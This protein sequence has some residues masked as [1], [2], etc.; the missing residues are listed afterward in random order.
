MPTVRAGDLD[1]HYTE[2]GA[3]LPMVLLHGGLATADMWNPE[4]VATLAAH[5]RVLL[6][7]SRGHGRT[8]NPAD[9][10]SYS[11]MADDVAA[12]CTAL[13]IRHPIIVGYSDG[14]QIAI[15]LGLRHPG[16]ARAH[17]LGGVVIETSPPYFEM[18]TSIGFKQAGKVDID[19]MRASWGAEHFEKMLTKP[20]ANWERLLEQ[21]SSL[22]FTVPTYTD[23]Q[24]GRIKEPC[25]VICGD[26]D[27]ASLNNAVRLMR[28]LRTSELAV[29]PCSEHGA[30]SKPLF[31]T[32]VLD[33]L[34]RH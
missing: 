20:H 34:T 24:L 14:A 18:L 22:W 32:N 30:A 3:G 29:V 8:P 10:L 1:V 26:R 17:V 31:W 12:F 9:T 28:A 7:D 6:P 16:L 11:Q 21:I 4:Y 5:H 15:E 19:S 2:R 27:R 25:L 33:F 23:E 13:E